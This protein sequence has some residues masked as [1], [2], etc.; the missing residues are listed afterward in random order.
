MCNYAGS[1]QTNACTSGVIGKCAL[2]GYHPQQ[3]EQGYS[4]QPFHQAC[5]RS[6]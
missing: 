2:W 1:D 3:T 5:T 4:L 6:S